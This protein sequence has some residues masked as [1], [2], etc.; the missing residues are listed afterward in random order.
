MN[1]KSADYY[2]VDSLFNEENKLVRDSVR[3]W[4]KENISPVIEE[5]NLNGQFPK[6]LIKKLAEIGGFGGIFPEEFGGAS[7][8]F[9]SYGLMMQ[10]LE[11]G[12]S[13]VRVFA[14]IQ[15]SLVM[16]TIYKYGSECIKKEYL[17]KLS[18][19]NI[20]GSFGMSEPNHGS[21]PSSM[22]T[23]FE[24]FEDYYLVNGSKMWIG[25]APICDIAIVWAKSKDN[26]YACFLVDIE[27]PGFSTSKIERKLSFRASETGEL[28][29]HD[30]RIPK[31][32]LLF[33]S[34]SFKAGLESLNLAR[35]AVA[36]G[37]QGIAMECYEIALNYSNERIQ[38]G[39]KI[40]SN[41]LI[42]K[43][44]VY[45]VTEITKCQLLSWRLG[46]LMNDGLA[47]FEQISMAKRNNVDVAYNIAR[48]SRQILGGM[49]ITAEYPVMRHLMNLETLITY[50][51]TDEIHTLITGRDITGVS[52]F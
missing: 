22:N 28:I 35:Y 13:S 36:W 29:F 11:R 1:T 2:K 32:Y 7:I 18:E 19:G 42:Q 30:A 14:S 3:N 9:I 27:T 33:E 17:N 25:N 38:F 51:G 49:G 48:Y 15:T 47:T 43:K 34:N 45:M 40:A 8:D 31:K 52:A 39:K 50:Q 4:V 24:E 10:E 20:I 46:K 6:D 37:A 41:Q 12:D 26:S 44:L 23:T 5:C 16:N 21:D